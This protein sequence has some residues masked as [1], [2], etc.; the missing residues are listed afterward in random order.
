MSVVLFVLGE[1]NKGGLVVEGLKEPALVGMWTVGAIRSCV[2]SEDA[3]LEAGVS[4]LL[5]LD[6]GLL[7]A[8]GQE[9]ESGGPREECISLVV[10][11]LSS[12]AYLLGV[13][14]LRVAPEG[15]YCYVCRADSS[16]LA[17]MLGLNCVYYFLVPLWSVV[18]IILLVLEETSGRELLMPELR[19]HV[20]E[21]T[22]ADRAMR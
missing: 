14:A 19:E 8:F 7:S 17:M 2:S 16:F 15:E 12:L 22:T 11:S 1:T 10:T 3:L 13:K 5:F 4:L 18:S 6:L 21:G 20:Y 9:L